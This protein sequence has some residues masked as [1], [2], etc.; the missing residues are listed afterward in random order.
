MSLTGL[1]NGQ[2][3]IIIFMFWKRENKK[4]NYWRFWKRIP[5]KTMQCALCWKNFIHLSHE[6]YIF[7]TSFYIW[8]RRMT[9]NTEIMK[10]K[11]QPWNKQTWPIPWKWCKRTVF[12]FDWPRK[13]P[14]KTENN[15]MKEQLKSYASSSSFIYVREIED[16]N[17][18]KSHEIN[19]KITTMC[20]PDWRDHEKWR[21][22][23]TTK[24][25]V[26]RIVSLDVLFFFFWFLISFHFE[27]DWS[28]M[29]EKK[30]KEKKKKIK[31]RNINF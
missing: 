28:T 25:T 9:T 7:R 18:E 30:W 5:T 13:D 23:T 6:F 21:L 22:T 2:K 27:C 24:Y 4:K 10:N 11:N 29:D 16:K 19:Q 3:E 26:D 14:V 1:G 8:N 31:E 15:R 20:T 17:E 12:S